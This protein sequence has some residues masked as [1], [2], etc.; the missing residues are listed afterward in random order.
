MIGA[1]NREGTRTELATGAA[2][3]APL[4]RQRFS[5]PEALVAGAGHRPRRNNEDSG[6]EVA[7]A[8]AAAPKAAPVIPGP[9]TRGGGVV[10][11]SAALALNA[12]EVP[13]PVTLPL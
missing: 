3:G 8:N 13:T 9:Q 10:P 1:N 4:K 7:M 6:G 12:A 2:A 11:T 5:K